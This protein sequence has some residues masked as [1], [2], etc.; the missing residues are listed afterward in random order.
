MAKSLHNHRKP[1][2]SADV[3]Q[4]RELAEGNTPTGVIGLKLGRSE[5]AVR[6]AAHRN[7]ISLTPS[8]RSPYGPRKSRRT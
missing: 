2:T 4:L 3:G 5:T 6:S 8:N 1:W 7:G